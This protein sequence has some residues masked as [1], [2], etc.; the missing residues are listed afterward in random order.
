MIYFL[1]PPPLVVLARSSTV[2]DNDYRHACAPSLV[3]VPQLKQFALYYECANIP[4]ALTTSIC[5]AFG[6][7][8]QFSKFVRGGPF[9][10]TDPNPNVNP[11]IIVPAATTDPMKYG[12]GHP[13]AVVPDNNGPVYLFYYADNDVP[14]APKGTYY[15]QTFDGVDFFGGAFT[16]VQ[17]APMQVKFYS[18]PGL[19]GRGIFLGVTNVNGRAYFNWSIDGLTWDWNDPT[20]LVEG[21][22]HYIGLSGVTPDVCVAP[23]TPS[24]G[25]NGYGQIPFANGTVRIF[26]GEGKYGASSVGLLRPGTHQECVDLDPNGP[27][28]AHYM[29][30]TWN[31]YGITG[32]FSFTPA[33]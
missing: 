6:I 33:P 18:G 22:P 5:V 12:S 21:G 26:Q 15:Q 24:F 1:G 20:K 4:N 17:L 14:N 9:P 27:E 3:L 31:L 23:G 25:A 16:G 29:G 30:Y 13:S 11:S 2:N 32:S 28:N 8:L 19:P 10:P 7:G